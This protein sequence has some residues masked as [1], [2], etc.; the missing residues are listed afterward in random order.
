AGHRPLAWRAPNGYPDVHAAWRSAGG[1]VETWNTHRMLVGDW[2]DGLTR[3]DP[4]ELMA[5]RSASTVGDYVEGLCHRLC[6]QG[7][8]A[9]H[10]DALV[11]F[12]GGDP[13]APLSPSLDDR[14]AVAAI[15]VVLDSPYFALR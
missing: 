12:L 7:F 1:V 9:D 2:K 15:A 14:A 4:A 6:F 10:R 8:R 3:P 11:A 13:A 5:G